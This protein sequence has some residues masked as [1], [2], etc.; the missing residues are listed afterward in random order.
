MDYLHDGHMH[1]VQGSGVDEHEIA[2]TT[3][4]PD[5]CR[6]HVCDAHAKDHVHGADCGHPAVPHAGHVDY[7]VQ[8]H[9]HHRCDGGHCDD[10]G[11]VETR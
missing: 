5:Q 4:N 10:H 8:G 1:S 7:L 9:L 3:T 6:P 11:P 2:A